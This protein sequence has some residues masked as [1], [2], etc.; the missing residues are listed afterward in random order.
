MIVTASEM[1]EAERCALAD[2]VSAEALMEEAALGI[3]R[4]VLG[5]GKQPGT[6]EVVCGKGNNAGDA[7][8]AACLLQ[9]VGWAVRLTPAYPF[10]E[11]EEAPR[12]YWQQLREA[13][14]GSRNILHKGP[15]VILDGLLGLGSQ[16]EPREPILSMVQYIERVRRRDGAFVVAVDGPSGLD[17]ESGLPHLSCVHADW[18]V[19]FG[20]CKSA[21]LSDEAT[22]YVG[23]I[24]VVPL[25]GLN[26]P[27]AQNQDEQGA[28]LL[29]TSVLR[30]WLAPRHFDSYKGTYGRVGIVAGSIGYLGAAV[31]C[32][33]G[34]LH[35]GAGL[36][37]LAAK[38]QLY[39]FL[40]TCVPPEVM[41]RPVADF[42]GILDEDFDAMVIGPGLVNEP[43]IEIIEIIRTA[44]CPAVIDAEAINLLGGQLKSLRLA[45]GPRILTPHPGEMRRL[46]PRTDLSRADVVNAFIDQNPCALLLK[47]ARTLIGAPGRPLYYN[48]TGHPGMGTGGMGDVLSGVIAA[49]AAGGLRSQRAAALGAWLCGRAAEFA[50]VAGQ[51]QESISAGMI[52]AHLGAAFADLRTAFPV[53]N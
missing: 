44:E 5:L 20:A 2:G 9:E 53:T 27:S 46:Y 16:G 52:T 36:V 24:E 25:R 26:F 31:L 47:G 21:L 29:T 1:L 6:C 14:G 3:A 48:S 40:A 30:S 7:L 38:P 41:V 18:T 35:G 37:T 28:E 32:A 22:D 15:Y 43:T 12:R 4:T 49:L 45:N 39:P 42:R 8:A 51:S 23:R 19:T 50:L 34:A 33:Q 13:R 11:M 10:E 17:W